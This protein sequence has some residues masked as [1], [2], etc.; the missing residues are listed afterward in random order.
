MYLIV[1]FILIYFIYLHYK[2]AIDA[3]CKRENIPFPEIPD[4]KEAFSKI[5][6][7][8]TH[9]D[10]NVPVVIYLPI[11]KNE[12]YSQFDPVENQKQ[13]GYCSTFN[14]GM[15]PEQVDELSGLSSFNIEES[16]E[17]IADVIRR[18]IELKT[19]QIPKHEL[20]NSS[21]IYI[22]ENIHDN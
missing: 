2:K 19:P 17:I 7:V 14:F 15:T 8:F 12:N 1:Q 22:V 21:N 16:K 6:S 4:F 13:R 20:E 10:S 11:K 18:V 5:C 9:P 3:F